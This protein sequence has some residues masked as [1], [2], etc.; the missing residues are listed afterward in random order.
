MTKNILKAFLP[1]C[2]CLG[3]KA[4]STLPI[5]EI[6]NGFNDRSYPEFLLFAYAN[7]F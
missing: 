7:L 5:F 6:L 1:V 4:P 2:C 3:F